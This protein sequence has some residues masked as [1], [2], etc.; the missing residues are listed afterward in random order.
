MDN[1]NLTPTPV[2]SGPEATPGWQPPTSP[3]PVPPP[4]T[5]TSTP[6]IPTGTTGGSLDHRDK[7]FAALSYVS[8]LFIVPLIGRRKESE[9]M[10][11]AKQGMVLF[12]A[13]VI[14]WFVLFV[15]EMLLIGRFS[16]LGTTIFYGIAGIFWLIPL[17]FSLMGIYYVFQGK[18]WVMPIIGKIAQKLKL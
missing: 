18:H 5:T 1:E 11:N 3:T 9:V 2:P 7:V 14:V 16:G 8:F 13:E 12:V 6:S 15:L 17:I 10:F 4:I